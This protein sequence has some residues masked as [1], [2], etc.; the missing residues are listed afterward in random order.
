[1]ITKDGQLAGRIYDIQGFTVQDGPGIR[2]TVFLKGCPLR[3]PWCHSPESVSFESQLSY[4]KMRCIGIEDCGA[5]LTNAQNN[6]ICPANAISL[7]DELQ[8]PADGSTRVLPRIDRELCNNCGECAKVCPANS[9]EMSGIDYT[10][11]EALKRVEKDKPFFES[12]GGGVTI[13]GGEPL[14]QPEFTLKFLERMKDAGIST[15]LDTTGFVRW[16]TLKNTVPYTDLYLYDIKHTDSEQHRKVVGV[17]NELIVENV[18]RLAEICRTNG[19]AKIQIRVPVIPNFND[20]AE[21]F[22]A[23]RDLCLK[24][25][26]SL[27]MIQLLPYHNLGVAKHERTM[28][29]GKVL[30]APPMEDESVEALANILHEACLPVRLH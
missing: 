24:L 28:T 8:S 14:S 6:V 21:N 30:E 4:L 20:T 5:C 17:P 2:D 19:N 7:G 15:A 10:V 12:S 25:G 22:M 27:T 13:S 9:L 23:L 18:I 11:D 29:K 1:M 3:C 26:D 16:E